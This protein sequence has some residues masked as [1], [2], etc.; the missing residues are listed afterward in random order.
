VST[1]TVTEHESCYT[2]V[3]VYTILTV[4]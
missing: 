3:A 1:V 4:L 2:S